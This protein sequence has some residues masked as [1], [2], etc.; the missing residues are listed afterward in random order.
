M[1]ATKTTT[2]KNIVNAEKWVGKYVRHMANWWDFA[3]GQGGYI[4]CEWTGKLLKIED[5][6]D[7]S[8]YF[9]TLEDAHKAGYDE[10]Y[11]YSHEALMQMARKASAL[12][13]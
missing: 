11:Y 3:W 4:V 5:E 13:A 8:N 2:K 1:T 10:C 7:Y 6:A 9:E 12:A